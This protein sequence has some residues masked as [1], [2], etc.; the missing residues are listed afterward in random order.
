MQLK[1]RWVSTCD[2]IIGVDSAMRKWSEQSIF[3]TLEISKNGGKKKK[4][5][6][7]RSVMKLVFLDKT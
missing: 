7:D 1:A 4:G 5:E 6:K 3:E 2:L